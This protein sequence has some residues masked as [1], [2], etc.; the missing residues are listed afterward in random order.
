[1]NMRVYDDPTILPNLTVWENVEA[2]ERFVWA[3]TAPAFLC[4]ARRVVRAGQDHASLVPRIAPPDIGPTWL[5]ALRGFDHLI[6]HGPSDHAF[7]VA[8]ASRCKIVDAGAFRGEERTR[9]HDQDHCRRKRDRR[10]AGVY[11]APGL[12]GC[13]CGDSALLLPRASVDRRQLPHVSHRGCRH[14]EAAGVVRHG[15][16]GSAAEQ[17]R[18]AENPQHQNA[19]GEKGARRRDG[20]P[21][22]QPS[23][24]LSDL[25]SGRRMRSAG[26]GDGVWRRR[27]PLSGEQARGR[28]QIYRAAGQDHHDALHP[29]HAL[30][31]FFD[32]GR[33]CTGAGR[34]R[35]RRG[36]GDHDLSRAR[37]D[38]GAAE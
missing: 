4:P 36:Y 8:A 17:G 5:K 18:I 37:D 14:P 31:S 7:R 11:A 6:A 10:P 2:L 38:L 15:R 25:R 13:G 29:L 23:A 21:A 35:P 28:G 34:H 22:D 30:H 12:R 24:R 27:Q 1:M 20:V 32:R 16:E 33:R 26:P 9:R 3:D 19:D